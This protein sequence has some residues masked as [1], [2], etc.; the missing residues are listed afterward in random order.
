MRILLTGHLGFIGKNFHKKLE[1][2]GHEVTGYDI[3]PFRPPDFPVVEDMD[4]V[5][6]L[7]GMSNTTERNPEVALDMNYDF[8][9]KLLM[10]CCLLYT[11]DAADE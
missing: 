5:I 6:H 7:G 1:S 2:M 4:L 3:K 11:S 8:S 10:E 9:Y